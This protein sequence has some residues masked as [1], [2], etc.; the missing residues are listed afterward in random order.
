MF[1]ILERFLMLCG[2]FKDE[3]FKQTILN[4]ELIK[5]QK[6]AKKMKDDKI[7]KTQTIKVMKIEL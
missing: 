5:V 3:L 7:S 1:L 2:Q 6:Q 4:Y